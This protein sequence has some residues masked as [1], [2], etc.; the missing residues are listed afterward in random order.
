M[1]IFRLA[2]DLAHIFSKCVL[3][4]SI[5]RNKS[6]EGISLLTQAMYAL[7]FCTRYLDLFW[8]FISLY[9][10]T[11]KVFY[12]ASSF[13]ILFLMLSVYPR[14]EENRKAWF[15]TA[16]SVGGAAVLSIPITGFAR[17]WWISWLMGEM[18][19]TFSIILESVCVIPQLIIL[20][21]T[22]IPTVINSHYLL[23]LGSYRG[24]YI[25]NWIYRYFSEGL[26]DPIA[27][28]F[29]VIQTAL[30]IDFARVYYGRQRIKLR[31]GVLVD[32]EDFRKGWITRWFAGRDS[33]D[34]ERG[35]EGGVSHHVTNPDAHVPVAHADEE[36]RT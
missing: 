26:V 29:G 27:V 4:W 22:D 12:I 28:V 14:T 17:G 5:H 21:Q 15:I 31:E 8:R 7:V 34:V 16:Y 13:Y 11:A 6:A 32:S 9:N 1:N 36:P 30:Y 3:L 10:T 2:G 25:L 19:W 24:F 33:V 20:R 23:T 35:E 18:F